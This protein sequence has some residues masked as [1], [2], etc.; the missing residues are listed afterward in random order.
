MN[1]ARCKAPA[2]GHLSVAPNVHE[3]ACASCATEWK[4]TRAA[5]GP[6]DPKVVL[7]AFRCFME[8]GRKAA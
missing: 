4:K 6:R 5:M 1:C 7:A 2:H 8:F 3:L